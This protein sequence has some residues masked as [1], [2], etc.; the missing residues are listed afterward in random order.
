MRKGMGSQNPD[1][2]RRSRIFYSL[3][4]VL[5][6]SI[7]LFL[8]WGLQSL[9]FPTIIGLLS[10]YICLPLL[11]YLV[12]KQIPRT[13]SVLLLF[14][15]FILVVFVVGSQVIQ[16]LPDDKEKL[17]LRVSFQHKINERYLALMGKD[18]FES[19]G[20]ILDQLFGSETLP[21]LEMA[22]GFLGLDEVEEKLFWEFADGFNESEPISDHIVAYFLETK[23]LPVSQTETIAAEDE[24]P[25]SITRDSAFTPGS[26]RIAAF[27]IAISNWVVMPFVFL[28][29]LIDDGEMKRFFIDLV[30][31][32][33]F[34]MTLT[35][36]DNVD[37]AIGDYLRGT[38]IQCSLVGSTLVIGLIIV[39]F[40][41]KAALVIGLIAGLANAIPFLGPFIGLV[42]GVTYTLIVENIEPLLPFIQSGNAVFGVL[43]AV[44]IVQFLDNTI[45]G[46]LVLGKAVNL[47]PLIVIMGVTGG[48]I[49][50]GF[51]GMLLAVPAIVI[52]TAIIATIYGQ[53]KAYQLIY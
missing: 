21:L 50:F 52:F 49:L 24:S 36:L 4:T 8:L 3:L 27:L 25:V 33:Y 20:N 31:N 43:I 51:A 37:K 26:S 47:H 41:L 35:T 11:N 19:E 42:V 7:A 9:I 40:D 29:F 53:L 12:S 13:I 32:R 14:G 23:N 6:L 48:S 34:E 30:P 46:P 38:L 5:L 44:V 22:N 1:I 10:A 17:E 2:L 18:N 28:F 39:G 45:F 16:I 15:G